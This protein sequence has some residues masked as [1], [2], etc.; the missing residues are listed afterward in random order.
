M[1]YMECE[2]YK[3]SWKYLVDL[4]QDLCAYMAFAGNKDSI[5]L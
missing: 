3:D 1:E 4:Q 5:S 2:L